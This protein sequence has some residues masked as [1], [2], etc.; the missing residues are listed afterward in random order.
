MPARWLPSW[1]REPLR[2]EAI[3]SRQPARL[4]GKPESIGGK[5]PWTVNLLVTT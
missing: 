5:K 1:T 4:F 2:H 3:E